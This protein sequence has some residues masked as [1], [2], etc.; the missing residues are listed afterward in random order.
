ML[1]DQEDIHN[2]AV[3]QQNGEASLNV[4][5]VLLCPS[6]RLVGGRSKAAQQLQ[7]CMHGLA[8]TMTS[9]LRKLLCN[10]ATPLHCWNARDM[11]G[12][13]AHGQLST[14][15]QLRQ[16]EMSSHIHTSPQHV[17]LCTCP[18]PRIGPLMRI[19]VLFVAFKDATGAAARNTLLMLGDTLR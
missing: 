6:A 9:A 14:A 7:V 8:L 10:R 3:E 11:R 2:R 5:T 18:A 4:A 15:V 19:H 1:T 17:R 12:C 16:P 13:A